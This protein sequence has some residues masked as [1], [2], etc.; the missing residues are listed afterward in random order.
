MKPVSLA[1]ETRHAT[2]TL[3]LVPARSDRGREGRHLAALLVG[4][5]ERDHALAR[6]GAHPDVIELA[7]PEGKERVGIEQVRV[8]IRATQFAPV[9][10][11]RKVCLIPTAEALTPEAANALLKTLEEPPREMAF[12][13]LAEHT[14]DLLPTIVSRSRIVRIAPTE[15][16]SVRDRLLELGYADA[17]ARWLLTVA[18]LVE[19]LDVGVLRDAARAQIESLG[20]A[21]LIAAAVG[22]ESILRQ[23]ALTTLVA[24]AARRDAPLLTEGIRTLASQKREALFAFLQDLLSVCHRGARAGAE[25]GAPCSGAPVPPTPSRL[26]KTCVAIDQAHRALSVHGPTEAILLS[27]FLSIG[28]CSDGR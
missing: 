15:P 24:R 18:D 11:R 4:E 13:L 20:A 16:A 19:K 10:G 12:V 28:G 8:A 22:G 25:G 17:E 1:E 6:R 23:T 9:Q 3:F 27:L 21:D 7:P 26:R 5:T 2:S 14:S